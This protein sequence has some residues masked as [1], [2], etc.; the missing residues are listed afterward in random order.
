[1]TTIVIKKKGETYRWTGTAGDKMVRVLKATTDENDIDNLNKR[2]ALTGLT[3]TAT[4]RLGEADP[5]DLTVVVNQAAV[6]QAGCGEITLTCESADTIDT[7]HYNGNGQVLLL[8][9]ERTLVLID[10]ALARRTV[11]VADDETP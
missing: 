7:T 10:M 9:E 2:V 6:G 8:P 4:V 11:G 1:M 3:V 5:F